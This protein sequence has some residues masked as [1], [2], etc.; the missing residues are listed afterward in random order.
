MLQGSQH[1]RL[2][3]TE[4]SSWSPSRT[5]AVVQCNYIKKTD[6]FLTIPWKT[7]P[8]FLTGNFPPAGQQIIHHWAC[9]NR[10][11][12][13]WWKSTS[14]QMSWNLIPLGQENC[15]FSPWNATS[16]RKVYFSSL[17][18]TQHQHLNVKKFPPLH[19]NLRDLQ[20]TLEVAVFPTSLSLAINQRRSQPSVPKRARAALNA[21]CNHAG[22]QL[23]FLHFHWGP[24]LPTHSFR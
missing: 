10:S 3:P 12:H 19:P 24:N 14:F 2:Y 9:F 4:V 18:V 1:W 15:S 23:A 22:F 7:T 11:A 6:S 8:P 16:Q 17:S 21:A 13:A 20:L 5:I